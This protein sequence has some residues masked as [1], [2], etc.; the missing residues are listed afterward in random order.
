MKIPTI[1]KVYLKIYLLLLILLI[2]NLLFFTDFTKNFT[3]KNIYDV[4][5]FSGGWLDPNG[6]TV[7]LDDISAEQYG[8]EARFT[9]TLPS[10]IKINEE[11]CFV[12]SNAN[13]RV[14]IDDRLCYE[15]TGSDNATGKGYG[16]AYITVNMGPEDSGRKVTLELISVFERK[17]GGKIGKVSICEA[18]VFR[19]SILKGRLLPFILSVFITMSGILIIILRFGIPKTQPLPYNIVALG[20][21]LTI[22]GIWCTGDS[23]VLQV[24]FGHVGFWRV[25]DY[26]ALLFMITPML[27]FLLSLVKRIRRIFS[28]ITFLMPI[29]VGVILV[30]CRYALGIDLERLDFLIYSAYCLTLIVSAWILI[31]NE[32]Y[33]RRNNSKARMQFF[34]IG[35][36]AFFLGAVI[37]IC[38]VIKNRNNVIFERG[39]FVRVGICIFVITMVVKVMKWWSNEQTSIARDRF[40]NA[41]LQYS[42]SSSDADV[43]IGLVMEY[44]GKELKADRAYIFE[45]VKNNLFDN[46]Y[47]WCAPGVSKEIDNLKGLPYEGVIDVWYDEYKKNNAVLIYDL[48]AYKKISLNMYEVLKPQGIRTLITAPLEVNG[49]YIGFFGVDNPPADMMNEI[50]EVLRLLAYFISQLIV[51][52]RYEDKLVYYSYYDSLT[53]ARNRRAIKEFEDND[54]DRTKPY[55]FIMCDI[56]GLKIMNDT[57]GH[58]AGDALL[59]DVTKSLISVFGNDNVYRVGGDEFAVYDCT[60]DKETFLARIEQ[61]RKNIADAGRSVS[62]GYI[63]NDTGEQDHEKI[64]VQVDQLMYEEKRKYYEGR[65]DRRR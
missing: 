8:G 50:R 14:W 37:D 41:I 53:G 35:G 48:E 32:L 17:N 58:E 57:Q 43:K 12:S 33:C 4:N 65:H 19:A 52:K 9:K 29:V 24:I 40:V 22:A 1:L 46:T 16:R 31:D 64:K 56:N 26:T 27:G 23:G 38:L 34:Y 6:Q 42:M 28:Q 47:E 20:Q 59:T 25:V 60:S 36:G 54:F 10:M 7:D 61:A 11:L 30:F 55:G 13:I 45:E 49:K 18:P 21:T 3:S 62:M 51:E 63:Y 44:L 39:Y 15:F 2:I 5:D